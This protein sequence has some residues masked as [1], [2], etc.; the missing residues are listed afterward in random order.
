[1]DLEGQTKINCMQKACCSKLKLY[2]KYETQF[3]VNQNNGDHFS[4]IQKWH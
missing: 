1:M 2:P 4:N 3:Q